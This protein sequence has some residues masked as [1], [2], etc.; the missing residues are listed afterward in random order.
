M[1][2]LRS[3]LPHKFLVN[4]LLKSSKLKP[5]AVGDGDPCKLDPYDYHEYFNTQER[6]KCE[7]RKE[8][9]NSTESSA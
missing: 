4:C 1:K 3:K 7:L 5:Y 6:A 2:Q 9:M 8:V